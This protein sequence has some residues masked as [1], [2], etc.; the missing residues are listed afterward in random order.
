MTACPFCKTAHG[1]GAPLH[2]RRTYRAYILRCK[3]KFGSARSL[4]HYRQYVEA[5]LADKP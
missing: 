1:P 4:I 2:L 3:R 5:Y